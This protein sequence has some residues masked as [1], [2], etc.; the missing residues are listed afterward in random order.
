MFKITGPKLWILPDF[1]YIY[2]VIIKATVMKS[3]SLKEQF[4]AFNEGRIVDS[5]GGADECFNFYDWFCKDS[6]LERK[7]KKLYRAA[8]KFC[9]KFN[10]DLEKHYVFFKNNCPMCGPLYDDFRICDRETGDVIYCVTPKSGHTGRAEVYCRENSFERP[11]FEGANLTEIWKLKK[12]ESENKNSNAADIL[13]F[14]IKDR[15]ITQEDLD[16]AKEN[17]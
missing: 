5:E 14:L 7:S 3:L 9:E 8:I 4:K 15:V 16:R 12:N 1:A 13:D 2:Y 6:S 10:V 17:I 11:L